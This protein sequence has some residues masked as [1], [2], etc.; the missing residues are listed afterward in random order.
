MSATR[1]QLALLASLALSL[2]ACSLGKRPVPLSPE[3]ARVRIEHFD[4][5]Q[6]SR[7]I[8]PIA[9]SDGPDCDVLAGMG[10]EERATAQ[11]RQAATRRG[12]DFVK[13]TKVLEPYS[14]H[15]CLHKR[16]RI[17]GLGYALT[18]A[19]SPAPTPAPSLASTPASTP[20]PTPSGSPT[21]P[22]AA[23]GCE[24][25]C[26][27]GYA[28][29]AG[30]CAA[31]CNPACGPGQFCRFDRVCAPAPSSTSVPERSTP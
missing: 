20:S 25:P 31:E 14:D 24:P 2:G 8:G 17:E 15:Y 3:Q 9:G 22:P 21:S 23:A 4:P 16:Y 19:N 6:G 18:P 10:T 11:L 28:C 12:I 1:W 27:T 7:L 26:A 30:V 5:P 13:V 29:R